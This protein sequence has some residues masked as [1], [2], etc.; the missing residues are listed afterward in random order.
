MDW[1]YLHRNK[2]D[3]FDKAI[4]CVDDSEENRN[5]QGKKKPTSL[6]GAAVPSK[7]NLRLRYH[8]VHIKE[9][10]NFKTA[11]NT[12]KCSFFQAEEHYLGHVVSKDDI[13]IDPEKIR[14]IMK[15]VTP[16]NVYEVRSFMGLAGYYRT[17][18]MNFSRIAYPITSLQRKG[19]KFEW[20]EECEANFEQLKQLL[21]HAPMLNITDPDKQFVVCIYACKRGLGGVLMQ[22]GNVVCYESRKLN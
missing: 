7:I 22:E 14:A 3:C 5:L 12:S 17:F 6:K 15:W 13:T 4:E 9:E 10:D 2:V 1:L 21:T 8:Q 16:K 19:K 20:T 11:F 18:I